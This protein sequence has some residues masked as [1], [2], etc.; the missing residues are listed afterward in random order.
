M[1]EVTNGNSSAC[2]VP[3]WELTFGALASDLAQPDP[4]DLGSHHLW[5]EANLIV[6]GK[7]SSI[8]L[9]LLEQ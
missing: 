8:G 7:H 9:T 3:L 1:P 2:H 5:L 4:D 6:T